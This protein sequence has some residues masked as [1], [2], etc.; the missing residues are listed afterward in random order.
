MIITAVS[1]P[2]GKPGPLRLSQWALIAEASCWFQ[3]QTGNQALSDAAQRPTWP[4]S[5]SRFNPKREARPSQTQLRDLTTSSIRLVS[6]PN[7][8]PGPLRR[9]RVMLTGKDIHEFQ[10]QT[11]S[12][13]LSDT[14]SMMTDMKYV[15]RFQSQTGSQALSDAVEFVGLQEGVLVSIPNGKPGP[16]RRRQVERGEGGEAV[17]IPNGKPGPLR[18][19]SSAARRSSER[20]VSIPNGKPG[21]LRRR[22]TWGLNTLWHKFQSQTGSQALSDSVRSPRE[23]SRT[24]EFQSQ[25]GSQALSDGGSHPECSES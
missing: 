11:G 19:C 3:S 14:V 23:H 12:Q 24:H 15:M 17:S 6:I 8:K 22:K 10:S 4:I 13:A 7:G 18:P 5:I 2:N 16:L 1:I 9:V 25:T 21:P 20:P